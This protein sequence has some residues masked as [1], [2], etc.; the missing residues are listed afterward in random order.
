MIFFCFAKKKKKCSFKITIPYD[1]LSNFYLL[2]FNLKNTH[3]VSVVRL[4]S[5]FILLSLLF[6]YSCVYFC[7]GIGSIVVFFSLLIKK[8]RPYSH[9]Q[10]TSQKKSW[11]NWRKER[12][13]GRI[14]IFYYFDIP[15]FLSFP[16]KNA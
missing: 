3:S 15:H 2:W 10:N 14:S 13:R 4:V 16:Q 5:L 9:A 11:Y 1:L 6:P 12:K 8:K 7:S